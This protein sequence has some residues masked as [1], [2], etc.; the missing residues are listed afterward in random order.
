MSQRTF[1]VGAK[2]SFRWMHR[3][4]ILFI[5]LFIISPV[6]QQASPQVVS[7]CTECLA[8]SPTSP[9][10]YYRLS[11]QY[12]LF[13]DQ[14]LTELQSRFGDNNVPIGFNI[15]HLLSS[16]DR[17]L[18]AL[19]EAAKVYEADI[20]ALSLVKADTQSW[21]SSAINFDSIGDAVAHSQTQRYPNLSTFLQVVLTLPVSN[22]EAEG[23]F[24]ALSDQNII[25][26]HNGP[27][28][29]QWPG[30]SRCS[31]RN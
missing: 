3:V 13:I 24:S 18:A 30:A 27:R 22:A 2:L 6:V 19:M 25:K 5:Y 8:T 7:Q 4:Q 31:Q 15:K 1:P 26:E 28:T 9:R 17:D 23:S 10:E 12:I 11:A 29:P 20:K 21:F 16:A 14:V